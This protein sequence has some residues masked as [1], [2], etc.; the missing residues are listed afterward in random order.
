[1]TG[2]IHSLIHGLEE[3][4]GCLILK[5]TPNIEDFKN[6][7][8][9]ETILEDPIVAATIGYKG[10][11]EHRGTL[12]ENFKLKLKMKQNGDGTWAFETDLGTENE[13]YDKLDK[14]GMV[15]FV[16][17]PGF[18]FN[19][20][21]KMYGLYYKLNDLRMANQDQIVPAKKPRGR[22][23]TERSASFI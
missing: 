9:L 15:T 11:Y 1:M 8:R 21:D 16:V 22:T 14:G 7:E 20:N 12:D 2:K 3:T 6:L 17:T 4:G 13:A 19:D 23:V 5:V 18:Y 10:G